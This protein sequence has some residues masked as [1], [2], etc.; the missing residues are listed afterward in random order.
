MLSNHGNKHN[1]TTT[2]FPD[3]QNMN[4]CKYKEPDVH[5]SDIIRLF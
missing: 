1:S 2:N 4:L 5:K 3:I